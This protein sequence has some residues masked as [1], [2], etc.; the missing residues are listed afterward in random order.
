MLAGRIFMATFV[1]VW[2]RLFGLMTRP[3]ELA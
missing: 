2:R 1:K 3:F